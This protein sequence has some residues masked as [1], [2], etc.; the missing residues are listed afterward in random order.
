MAPGH[1]LNEKGSQ[2][3]CNQKFRDPRPRRILADARV[4]DVQWSSRIRAEDIHEH[5]GHH[6]VSMKKKRRGLTKG[7][8]Q[9]FIPNWQELSESQSGNAAG[10]NT[11]NFR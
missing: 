7:G 8:G 1:A 6:K 2:R 11:A 4:P 5:P 9:I 10:A 3:E